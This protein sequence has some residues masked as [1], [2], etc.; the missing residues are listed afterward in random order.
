MP[1]DRAVPSTM[2]IAASTALGL[3]ARIFCGATQLT[4]ARVIL[5][6][7]VLLGSPDSFSIP[8][9]WRSSP[10]AGGVLVTKENVRSAYTMISTGT[11]V[12]TMEAVRSLYALQNSMMFTPCCPSAGPTGG[13]GVAFPAGICNLTTAMTFFAIPQPQS[14]QSSRSSQSHNL[15]ADWGDWGDWVDRG[16]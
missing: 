7:L 3:R 13:A 9:A 2:R 15:Q 11:I 4:W 12:P 16:D 10:D 5:P 14:T 8:A 1:M 6:S